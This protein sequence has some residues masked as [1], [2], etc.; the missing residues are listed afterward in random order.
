MMG[1]EITVVLGNERVSTTIMNENGTRAI[2]TKA[3]AHIGE[4]VLAG[5]TYSGRVDILGRATI[6]NYIPINGADGSSFSCVSSW[7]KTIP[8][9]EPSSGRADIS[10]GE[11]IKI[12]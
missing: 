7:E 11:R 9:A 5:N 2:G 12:G 6:A 3:D 1:C 4:S 10:R 8:L